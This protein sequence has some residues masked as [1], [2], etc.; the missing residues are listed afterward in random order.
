[1]KPRKSKRQRR[2]MRQE[3][4]LYVSGLALIT[5]LAFSF[6]L[7][8][9]FIK[10]LDEAVG[11]ALLMEARTFDAKYR[12]DSDTPLSNA[13]SIRSFLDNLDSAPEFYRQ[14]IDPD[15]LQPGQFSEYHWEPFGE[16]EWQ[17][18]RYLIVYL[19]LL[20]DQRRLIVISDYQGNL[21]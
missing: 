18:S 15:T 13:S 7:E 5:A 1:M 12:Q 21:L 10:G 14:L 19:H 17:D 16:E 11:S 6:A 8:S 3:L 20:P 4:A 9:F 2:T